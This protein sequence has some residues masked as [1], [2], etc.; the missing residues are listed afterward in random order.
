RQKPW[1]DRIAMSR[2][3]KPVAARVTAHRLKCLERSEGGS[4]SARGVCRSSFRP[5]A[6]RHRLLS[7]H[8][9]A[10]AVLVDDLLPDAFHE[11]EIVG[12]L[13]WP[14]LLSISDD[15][16]RPGDADAFQLLGER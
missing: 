15:R 7:P 5:G 1:H 13:E 11:R 14:V 8:A 10:L 2:Q 9:N 12:R 6:A 16:L 4:G 3:K